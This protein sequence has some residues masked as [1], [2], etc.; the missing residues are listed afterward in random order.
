MKIKVCCVDEDGRY[1]GPQSRMIDVYKK[2]NFNK[3]KYEFVIPSNITIFKKKLKK[4]NAKFYEFQITRLSLNFFLFLKYIIFFPLEI[5]ILNKFFIEKKYDLIQINGV[6]HFKSAIAAKL[7]N[8]PVVWVV[9]DSYS[10]KILVLIFKIVVKICDTKIIY[11]SQKVYDFYLK[12]LNINRKNLYKIMSPTNS[13]YF[14]GKKIKNKKKLNICSVSGF[15]N[16]KDPETFLNVAKD[17]IKKYENISF[18]FVGRGTKNESRY[19]KK[20]INIYNSL[21]PLIKKKIIFL[22]MRLDIKKILKKSD[23]F[24]CTSKSEGGPIVV[25]EAMSM[26]LPVVTTNVG[27]TP[28]YIKN[29][30]SGYICNIGDYKGISQKILKLIKSFNLRKK[31]GTR[32]RKVVEQ[33]L[34]SKVISKKYQKVYESVSKRL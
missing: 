9:E 23:I 3:F 2:M 32:S 26:N 8:I 22:G 33:F 29:G 28:E 1:G 16:V 11:L 15:L 14:K 12:D 30:Y 31:F 13:E 6:P 5:L 21:D 7:S 25:W 17:V 34:D 20:I 19:Y 10:P 24:L 4:I 18:Y 27:G